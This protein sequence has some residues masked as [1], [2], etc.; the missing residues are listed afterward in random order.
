[1]LSLKFWAAI[2][3]GGCS[4]LTSIT[5][6]DSVTSI[7][8]D[9]FRGT[10][11]L[12]EYPDDM[13]IINHILY[14][15][16]GNAE[17]VVIPE[18]VTSIEYAAF[19][20]CKSLSGIDIPDGVTSIGSYAFGYCTSLTSITIPS[21]VMSIENFAFGNCTSLASINISDGVKNIKDEAFKYCE[22]L[23]SVTIPDSVTSI[24]CSAFESKTILTFKKNGGHFTIQLCTD[25][26]YY[27]Q[28]QIEL[29]NRFIFETADI[30]ERQEIFSDMKKACYKLPLAIFMAMTEENDEFF[31]TYVKKNIKKAV[32]Y[33]IDFEDVENVEK[34]LK[35]GYVTKKNI[36][37]FIEYAIEK[38][39]H[40]IYL[41][42]LNYKNDKIGFKS[43]EEMFKL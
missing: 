5:I 11:W 3:S 37:E 28:K 27:G 18:G 35:L 43:V 23:K 42:L 16:K 24:G 7:G 17:T 4:S 39:Q 10:K 38:E 33:L 21:S 40:E 14:K 2:W 13:V 9:A 34:I 22:N 19:N 29:L 12:E 30:L 31:H 20:H 6:S 25:W 36:D 26:D 8:V 1:L 15:Y 32:K 41:V